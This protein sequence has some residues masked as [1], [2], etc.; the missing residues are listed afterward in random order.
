MVCSDTPRE[1]C[2]DTPWEVCPDTPLMVCLDTN[3]CT[4]TPQ[5]VCP[6]TPQMVCPDTP[7]MVCPD[8]P[9]WFVPTRPGRMFR[10]EDHSLESEEHGTPTLINGPS[11]GLGREE[12]DRIN[13]GIKCA[14]EECF[15]S[16]RWTLVLYK[17]HH[18]GNIVQ[19]KADDEIEQSGHS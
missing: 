14:E 6:D 15:H 4:D 1:V 19:S 18:V 9:E 17:A 13:T 7:R 2:L 3:H 8:T 5:E 12:D 16:P 10:A 11:D